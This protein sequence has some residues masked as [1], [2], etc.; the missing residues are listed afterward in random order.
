MI[1]V[2]EARDDKAAAVLEA[3]EMRSVAEGWPAPVHPRVRLGYLWQRAHTLRSF[4]TTLAGPARETAILYA[5]Y[6][7]EQFT[8]LARS[9]G[10]SL[11][12]IAVLEEQFAVQ[13][14]DGAKALAI[15]RGLDLAKLDPQDLYITSLALEA[16]G[17]RAAAADAR[18]RIEK[19][20]RF[21]LFEA[22]YA[23]LARKAGS[24]P[25]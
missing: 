9:T 12:S 19:Q 4:A 5:E 15:A 22:T 1:F 11:P 14:G 17:D 23:Y 25:R 10:I 21:G 7:R 24:A 16:G 20:T 6:A 3:L 8:A 13:D 18:A 2:S